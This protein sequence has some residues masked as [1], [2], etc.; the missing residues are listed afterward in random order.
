ILPIVEKNNALLFYPVA[1]EG[2]ECSPNV[3]YA[4]PTPNQQIIP[5]IDWI[6]DK[7]GANRQKIFFLGTDFVY[8]RTAFLIAG[9]HLK[10]MNIEPVGEDYVPFGHREFQALVQK[11]KNS[12]ATAIFSCVNGDSNIYF[13]NELAAQG[14]TPEKCPVIA[15]QI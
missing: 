8:P 14:L 10:T 7:K 5:A 1:Y 4:A 12:G 13:Y 15:T 11:I 2:V 3:I 6:L 9:K